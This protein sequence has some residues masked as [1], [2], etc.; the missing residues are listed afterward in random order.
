MN[1][2]IDRLAEICRENLLAEKWLLVHS[3]R[4]GH[5]W[6]DWVTRRGQPVVNVRLKT[7]MHIAYEWIKSDAVLE[8]GKAIDTLGGPIVI[9]QIWA[10]MPKKKSNY[11]SSLTPTFQLFQKLF[12][13]I[14]SLRVSN[15]TST[16]LH[17][18]HFERP[19]KGMDIWQLLSKYEQHLKRKNI[20]DRAEILKKAIS[21][22]EQNRQGIPPETGFLV[23]EETVHHQ[24]TAGDCGQEKK[25]NNSFS[26]HEHQK[27]RES[28]YLNKLQE[29]IEKL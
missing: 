29:E 7:T 16:D 27:N 20:L 28:K 3:L 12:S 18:D 19:A 23:P 22:T 10:N 11:L 17:N 13:T 21:V 14:E 24:N 9:Q 4:I 1:V 5:Q 26:L 25:L 15:I 6:L 2:F 8:S